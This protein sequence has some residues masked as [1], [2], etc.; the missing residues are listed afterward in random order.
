MNENSSSRRPKT[1]TENEII[2]KR[3][4]CARANTGRACEPQSA[5]GEKDTP[6]PGGWRGRWRLK[7]NDFPARTG[8]GNRGGGGGDVR[9]L[10]DIIRRFV[11]QGH[12]LMAAARRNVAIFRN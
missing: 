8:E 10:S 4:R 11:G 3:G 1:I 6:A 12:A 2:L 5:G 9:V 7:R